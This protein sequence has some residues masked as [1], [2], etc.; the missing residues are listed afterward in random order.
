MRWY[1]ASA[2]HV[3]R[4]LILIYLY[5]WL[6]FYKHGGLAMS[7]AGS[8][9]I[10]LLHLLFVKQSL[11][12]DHHSCLSFGLGMRWCY[13]LQ[14]TWNLFVAR[15][16]R[17]VSYLSLRL[18]SIILVN[19]GLNIA[20]NSIH[21][22]LSRAENVLL[23]VICWD[24]LTDSA[25]II[26]LMGKMPL[27]GLWV[28]WSSL[29]MQWILSDK[30]ARWFHRMVSRLVLIYLGRVNLSDTFSHRYLLLVPADAPANI[31]STCLRHAYRIWA[32]LTTIGLVGECIPACPSSPIDPRWV[33]NHLWVALLHCLRHERLA[34]I[35]L[36]CS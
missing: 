19:A 8:L 25:V 13:F 7:G 24:Y 20:P 27:A 3:V 23:R 28:L 2:N 18:S 12:A 5:V 21:L 29:H 4:C 10:D 31:H 35:K 14:H 30:L 32:Q 6:G 9:G 16:N 26:V 15:W 1:L 36:R 17:P 11:R 22:D 33:R 34:D